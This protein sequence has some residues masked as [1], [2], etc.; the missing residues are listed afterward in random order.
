MAVSR[1]QRTIRMDRKY[2]IESMG[3]RRMMQW[4]YLRSLA[5]FELK[6]NWGG[7]RCM[8]CSLALKN[9]ARC[10]SSSRGTAVGSP[11]LAVLS[12]CASVVL[13]DRQNY[14]SVVC[15]TFRHEKNLQQWL[16][17]LENCCGP[18]TYS[19][20]WP[21]GC[22]IFRNKKIHPPALRLRTWIDPKFLGGSRLHFLKSKDMSSALKA[23]CVQHIQIYWKNA[24]FLQ[25]KCN[26]ADKVD[27]ILR[28]SSDIN[29]ICL[30]T[31][32]I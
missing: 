3:L 10:H 21:W 1:E 4:R 7:C 28:M 15:Q 20:I 18:A 23:S 32:E 11:C 5:P 29:R 19:M 8:R 2:H 9:D 27:I 12:W 17:I 13:L 25:K 6:F 14:F 30:A 22:N 16:Q 31:L 26:P 24:T